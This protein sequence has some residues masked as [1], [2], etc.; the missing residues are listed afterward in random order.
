MIKKYSLVV[1]FSL[2]INLISAQDFDF[3]KVS[4]KELNEKVHPLDSSASAAYL[5][6]HKK[7][8]FR[9]LDNSG[10]ELV[11]EV[12]ERIK[13]YNKEGYDFATK[14]IP[15][16]KASQGNREK[17]IGLKAVTYNLVG[18]KIEETKLKKDGIFESEMSEFYDQTKFTMP[19][20]KDGSVIEFKYKINSPF[21]FNVDEFVFQHSIPVNKLESSFSSPEYYNYKLNSRGYLNIY[22]KITRVNSSLNIK[23]KTRS[24]MSSNVVSTTFSNDKINFFENKHIYSVTDIPALKEEPYINNIDNYRAAAKYELSYVQYPNSVPKYYSSTWKDVVK[25][26]Y[27]SP[28]FGTELNK[29]G[30]YN[31]DIDP[32]VSSLSDPMQKAA[33]IYNYV[34]S[35]VKWNGIYGKYTYN[36]VRKAYKEN[37]GNVADINLMLTSMLRYAGLNANPVLVSTRGNGVPIFP[38]REG[39]NYVISAIDTGEGI[40]LLDATSMYSMPNVLPTRVLNWEGRIIA[41]DGASSTI[42]LYPNEQSTKTIMMTTN[43]TANGD[44]SGSYRKVVKLHNARIYRNNYNEADEDGYIEKIEKSLDLEISDFEVKNSLDIGK[45]IL[46]SY[47][48]VK[49]S[50]ADVIGDKIYFS[51]MFFYKSKSNPFKLEKRSY[52]IDFSYP[53]ETTYRIIVDIPEGYKVETLPEIKSIALPEQLGSFKYNVTQKNNQI[54]LL[55]V[56]SINK[57]IITPKYYE[58]VKTYYKILI[59]KE[60]EKVVLTK[61]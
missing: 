46:E 7:C 9:Y 41:K 35:K 25:T 5:Y 24:S 39:Y 17:I 37:V 8:Y 16:Y 59:E 10:F 57:A 50:Q 15:L 28:S 52:P 45:P 27:D 38:T 26:I 53:S 29:T 13:I 49:E 44:L 23:S 51:P 60:N 20:I 31:Q 33:A 30:Y 56:E 6:K 14:A 3:G 22:P 12:Y 58:A 4:T 43:L 61:I 19:N 40:I 48:F 42:G 36:G 47:K 34:K 54:H 55:V 21:I 1:L 11:T 18:N 32:L 2:A